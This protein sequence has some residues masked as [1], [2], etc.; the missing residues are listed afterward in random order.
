MMK[1]VETMPAVGQPPQSSKNQTQA[2]ER[3]RT[4]HQLMF[5][6]DGSGAMSGTHHTFCTRYVTAIIQHFKA[7]SDMDTSCAMV[8]YR[9]YCAQQPVEMMPFT[10]SQHRA[11]SWYKGIDFYGGFQCLAF[12]DGLALAL[13]TLDSNSTDT[14]TT[15]Y[16]F[17]LANNA[18][19]VAP[20]NFVAR[21]KDK[22]Y[23]DLANGM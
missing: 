13:Q 16:C 2:I 21:Y 8:V 14:N 7:L 4:Q 10:T 23:I 15:Q 1:R 5:L 20:V 9:D 11:L 12:S 22:T 17:V 6:I 3:K 19:P 18:F